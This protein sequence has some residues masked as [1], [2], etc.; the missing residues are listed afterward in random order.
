MTVIDKLSLRGGVFK[1][2]DFEQDKFLE[3][4]ITKAEQSH[5]I[6][7]R[8]K[9]SNSTSQT[10][11]PVRGPH[12]YRSKILGII[13]YDQLAL[14]PL[15]RVD[16]Q[17]DRRG[18]L[19]AGVPDSI[20][21]KKTQSIPAL[22]KKI[23]GEIESVGWLDPDEREHLVNTFISDLAYRYNH[24]DNLLLPQLTPAQNR[25][26][27]LKIFERIGLVKN[28]ILEKCRQKKAV[29]DFLG[30][31]AEEANSTRVISFFRT[32][33]NRRIN[34]A[35]LMS[36][37][38]AEM[39]GCSTAME[40]SAYTRQDL[41]NLEVQ[42]FKDALDSV[43]HP[44]P[45]LEKPKVLRREHQS[46]I[47]RRMIL[48]TVG[49]QQGR[50]PY[51]YGDRFRKVTS[52]K[53]SVAD[54]T[55]TAQQDRLDDDLHNIVRKNELIFRPEDS[56][57]DGDVEGDSRLSLISDGHCNRDTFILQAHTMASTY[58]RRKFKSTHVVSK[59]ERY[60]IARPGRKEFLTDFD[61][62]I[63]DREEAS[64]ITVHVPHKETVLPNQTVVRCMESKVS[65]RVP[66]GFITLSAEPAS[67][68]SEF[69]SEVDSK[70]LDSL[71][72]KLS[73][74]K[75]VEELYD[76][77]M[78]TIIG[79]HLETTEDDSDVLSCPPAPFDPKIPLSNAFLGIVVPAFTRTKSMQE[80]KETADDIQ[81]AQDE[82]FKDEKHRLHH[83][84]TP[85]VRLLTRRNTGVTVDPDDFFR[86]RDAAM[87]KTPSSRY[88][89]F[90]YNFGGFIPYDIDK[91]KKKRVEI[92]N[93]DD[94]LDF[95]RTRTCDFVLDLLVDSEED[96]KELQR[97]MEEEAGRKTAED[98]RLKA[99]EE[100]RLKLE[101]RRMLTEFN[102][103][104]WN[105]GTLEFMR[106]IQDP[107]DMPAD[108]QRDGK[109]VEIEQKEP[110]KETTRDTH[111]SEMNVV[112]RSGDEASSS[113]GPVPATSTHAG[114]LEVHEDHNVK[115]TTEERLSAVK[116]PTKL[117]RVASTVDIRTAQRELESL[118]VTLKMPLDQKLDMAIK[119][120][121]FK[122]APKLE[123]AIK[124][125]KLASEHI[126][127][128]EQVLAE[129]EEFERKASDPERFFKKGYDGSSE[130]RL[131][132]AR[133]RE[134]F[135]GKLHYMEARI[136]DVVSLI[137]YE[138]NETVT[139]DG[140]PY[141]EKIKT[142]YLDIIKNLSK[143]KK[144]SEI[145]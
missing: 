32:E 65:Q 79:S 64:S 85:E 140:V 133:Q 117:T 29:M 10:T 91:K 35:E 123:M 55:T 47:R 144:S 41:L 4:A 16:Q 52:S 49:G 101:R 105:A 66:K 5:A 107:D 100:K 128:R 19:N 22:L 138:L 17:N 145:K 86:D 120:G 143:E 94:Y 68:V 2:I 14:K 36:Q 44:L 131:L 96:A 34:T 132:E 83:S 8:L 40:T 24:V 98:A 69:G 9:K 112:E 121:S 125:W 54:L 67:A 53:L 71:D 30:I 78:K 115:T 39:E 77:I 104:V 12:K 95:L 72:E 26:L 80:S 87:R 99:E 129:L 97:A 130:A 70:V 89:T 50:L 7:E 56:D 82:E 93:P 37:V 136:A 63:F 73:R 23:V 58:R 108:N 127:S 21:V 137:K 139:Y 1:P 31:F 135:L 6:R 76:E 20:R 59:R 60:L 141:M 103:G 18:S 81:N 61:Y 74:F 75:E 57:E 43:T 109:Q 28:I 84:A 111:E 42:E 48:E 38:L 11:T 113:D 134:E 62:G 3:K 25:V 51:A 88:A 106:E 116:P 33:L 118:W 46:V 142:D 13:G 122:F 126:I 102:R 90:K 15:A 114:E 27:V 110:G 124:L 45:K 119:Y 92:F